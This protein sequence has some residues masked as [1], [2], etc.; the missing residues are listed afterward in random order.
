[1]KLELSLHA[2]KLKNVAGAFKGTSDPFAVV[3]QIATKPGAK[4]HVLGKTEV[5]KNNLSPQ[6]VKI[7]EIDYELGSAVKVAVSIY[8]EVKKSDNKLMGSA[9]FDIGELL[10]AR[11]NT[12]AKKLKKGG[13]LFATVR[14]AQG[15][16][17]LRF[18][19]KGTKL[20]NVEGW[21][22]KSDPFF[23]LSRKTDTAGG[24]TWDNCFRSEVVKN[25]LNPQ[26]KPATVEL[27]KLCGGDLDAP[28]KVSVFDYESKGGHVAMGSFETSVNGFL[29]APKSGTQFTLQQKGKNV[30]TIQVTQASVS[31]H[32]D[33]V[34]E[35][36]AAASVSP[37]APSLADANFVDYVSGGCELNV[38]VAID[39]TGSNGDPRKPGTLHYLHR[40]QPSVRNDYEKVS[41]PTVVWYD[42]RN[43]RRLFAHQKCFII[44]SSLRQFRPSCPFCPSMIVIKCT[45]SLVLE[46]N[47]AVWF[48]IAFSVGP[49]QRFMESKESWMPTRR[50]LA[51]A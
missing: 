21:I 43:V 45:Q 46:R 33:D 11:G 15:K 4:P 38:M 6:W 16:G 49:K 35:R 39:F 2:S 24:L 26:F 7:F 9:V 5:F 36:M 31:G 13:T 37:V 23:E 17:L 34:S 47:T 51:V 3:T 50:P 1:M 20:K 29:R 27:S 19:M 48:V 14:K 32:T 42:G 18:T 10:G 28:I 41:A 44:I 12:K 30:G 40:G 25:N 8:D 22:G